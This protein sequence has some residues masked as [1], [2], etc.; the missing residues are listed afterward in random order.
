MFRADGYREACCAGL[1]WNSSVLQPGYGAEL[2]RLEPQPVQS[3]SHAEGGGGGQHRIITLRQRRPARQFGVLPVGVSAST[4]NNRRLASK[5][6]HALHPPRPAT[7][8]SCQSPGWSTPARFVP[9]RGFSS[10]YCL[11][12]TRDTNCWGHPALRRS[13]WR[14]SCN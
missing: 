9:P 8:C 1:P 14:L 3:S 5:Q 6:P 13:T 10:G 4:N 11:S 2:R 12:P 7:I